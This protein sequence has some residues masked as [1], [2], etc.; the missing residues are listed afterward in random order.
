MAKKKPK[1]QLKPDSQRVR[2]ILA[3][4]KKRY[5]DAHCELTHDNPL[6]LLIS[7]ILSAQCTDKRVNMVTPALF[8]RFPD[9]QAFAQ[10]DPE[11]LMQMI[12]STGF[13]QNKAKNIKKCCQVIVEKHTG[14]V[15]D[16]LEDLVQLG[17]VGRKTANVILGNAFGKPAMVVDTHV[18]RISNLL[19]LTAEQDPVKIEFALMKIIPKKDWTVFS[20]YL[21]SHGR[22]TCKARRPACDACEISQHCPSSQ[23]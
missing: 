11:E 4:L 7:T 2:K 17:G 14:H 3:G 8:D 1:K 16:N 19:G 20:H 21:I 23:V 5:P 12:R 9:A 15:P 13:Y 18:K 10:A 22:T 6:Q